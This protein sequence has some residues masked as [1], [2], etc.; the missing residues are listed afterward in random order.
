MLQTPD[1]AR[2]LLK[3]QPGV[4]TEQIEESLTARLE[5]QAI[6][7]RERPPLLW[8]LMDEGVLHHQV[9][10]P[11]VMY[12]QLQRLCLVG[13][14]PTTVPRRAFAFQPP[15][16]L[17]RGPGA[18]LRHLVLDLLAPRDHDRVLEIGTGTGYTTAV[19]SARVGQGKVTS[20]E[21]DPEVA[22]QAAAEDAFA[23][24]VGQDSPGADRFG[25]VVSPE[26]ERVWLDHPSHLV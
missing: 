15:R 11:Q 13:H 1:Y 18:G 22:K 17:L 9:G 19:L 8:A 26:G 10:N 24:W 16:D 23:W 14:H 3:A 21:V 25:L 20:I 5:R 12:D 4:T 2:E 7:S 6:L